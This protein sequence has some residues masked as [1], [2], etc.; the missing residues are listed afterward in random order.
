MLHCKVGGAMTTAESSHFD[1]P[2]GPFAR[3][4]VFLM[5]E[6]NHDN[7]HGPSP[8]RTWT[9]TLGISFAVLFAMYGLAFMH[10]ALPLPP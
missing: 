2:G 7:P 1:G 3:G 9:V 10:A 5:S 4:G 6:G 8:A